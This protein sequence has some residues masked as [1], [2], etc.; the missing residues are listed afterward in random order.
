MQ[1]GKIMARSDI[2]KDFVEKGVR[3]DKLSSNHVYTI[4]IISAFGSL[5][6]YCISSFSE[7]NDKQR[8]QINEL[9]KV[10]NN[11]AEKVNLSSGC[12]IA[13]SLSNELPK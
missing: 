11:L 4:L 7:A 5:S 1:K 3:L 6:Y 13:R 2:A 8:A 12:N 10:I 9:A